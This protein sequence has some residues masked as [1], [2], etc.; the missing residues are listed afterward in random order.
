M[1]QFYKLP[2]KNIVNET[3]NAVSI[4]LDVPTNLKEIFSFKS[5]QYITFKIIIN[6]QEI[7]RDYSICSSVNSGELKVAVKAVE[8]GVFSIY[9]NTQLKV[10]DIVE[11]SAPNGRFVFEPQISTSRTIAAFAAG[12]GITP[13]LGIA[14]TILEEEPLSTFILVYG[15]KTPKDTIFYNELLQLQQQYTERFKLQFVFSQTD[16]NESLFGRIDKSVVNF[17]L[18]NKFSQLNPTKFYLCGPETMIHTVKDT[19]I[20]NNIAEEH[21]FFELFTTSTEAVSEV[22]ASIIDGTTQVTVMVDDEETTFL[23]PQ[24]KS[25]L[26]ATLAENIDAPYSCQGGIC[27][28]CLARLTEGEATMRQN[29]ILTDSE[30]A[31]GLILTCQAHPT[32]SVVYVD[33]DDV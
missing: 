28:S 24:T 20:E 7:R 2:I 6:N 12:S 9:A 22:D 32:T 29:N 33:Y 27:S 19:L 10:G 8:N 26:E 18:K 5:G 1:S 3:N 16:E 30:L 23:M 4:T 15:N 14:K 25:I 17:V 11:V 31:E 13:I 21:I